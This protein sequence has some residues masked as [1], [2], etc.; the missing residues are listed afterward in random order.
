MEERRQLCTVLVNKF[1]FWTWRV[2]GRLWEQPMQLFLSGLGLYLHAYNPLCAD[3]LIRAGP[4]L[5]HITILLQWGNPG[6][7]VGGLLPIHVYPV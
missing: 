7:D 4:E 1:D 3:S 6:V 2:I 5:S